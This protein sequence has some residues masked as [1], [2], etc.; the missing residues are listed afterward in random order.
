MGKNAKLGKLLLFVFFVIDSQDNSFIADYM[1]NNC[2]VG[3]NPTFPANPNSQLESC[4]GFL[5]HRLE[6]QTVN[7]NVAGSIPAKP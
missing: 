2:Y 7:L 4:I 1:S 3:S 6:C 5:T